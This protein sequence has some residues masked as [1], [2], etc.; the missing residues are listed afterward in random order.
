MS[1]ILTIGV[2]AFLAVVSSVLLPSANASAYT[3]DEI[4]DRL[5]GGVN[6]AI[7]WE[8]NCYDTMRANRAAGLGSRTSINNGGSYAQRTWISARG[9][10]ATT[11]VEVPFG[12]R[13]VDLQ[14]N[15]LTFLC[16]SL[17]APTGAGADYA[18][19]NGRVLRD[20]N[21][22]NDRAPNG[23]YSASPN[24]PALTSARFRVDSSSADDGGAVSL[25]RNTVLGKNRSESSRYWFASP[26]GF[27]YTSPSPDGIRT[28]QT[29]TVRVTGR[30]MSQ[31]RNTA[32]FCTYNVSP[33]YSSFRYDL[34]NDA[35]LVFTIR[36]TIAPYH[37]LTPSTSVN[38]TT[39]SPGETVTVSNQVLNTG[40]TPSSGTYYAISTMTYPA[41][42]SPAV[43]TATAITNNNGSS[44]V[45]PSVPCSYF[46]STGAVTCRQETSTPATTGTANFRTGTTNFFARNLVA[47]DLAVGTRLCYALSVYSYNSASGTDQRW[48]HGAPRCMVV[49]KAPVVN[50]TG[51]DVIVGKGGTGNIVT[52][53]TQ[54]QVGGTRIFG[55]WGEYAI[56]ASGEIF[57]MASGGGY[58]GGSTNLNVCAAQLLSFANANNNTT[59]TNATRKGLYTTNGTLPLVGARFSNQFTIPSNQTRNLTAL[60]TGVYSATGT[61]T[62]TNSAADMPAGKWVVINAPTATVNITN[63]IT[64]SDGPFDSISD[65]PQ[66]IIVANRI[67]IAGSVGRVDAWLVA[68]GTTGRINTCSDVATPVTLRSTICDRPLAVNGPV[69]ARELLLYRTAGAGTGADAGDPAELFNL[70]PDAY[71]WAINYQA[72]SGRAQTVYSQELPPRF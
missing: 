46:T 15:S 31:Y 7:T 56:A 25:A 11:S 36:V 57:S 12:T 70:R 50:V 33:S 49:A 9:S 44:A 58:S 66:L 29:I 18:F 55:S 72:N 5:V 13:V 69:I 32:H 3:L 30:E 62:L 1:K 2:F 34:C 51:G 8:R 24:N 10:G 4:N 35:T 27:T 41:G 43:P 6:T 19:S 60:Q 53:S 67:N 17:V 63:D 54:R 45:Q 22:P 39:I 48:R 16:S 14:L 71:L 38:R 23:I 37:D 68:T 65:I 26:L 52:Q 64:Y 28:D 40:N 42:N 20:D 61:L 21:K 47:G 59:C